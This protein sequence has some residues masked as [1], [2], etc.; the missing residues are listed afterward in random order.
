[1]RVLHYLGLVAVLCG[2][3]G[4][5][6]KDTVLLSQ[7][8]IE[9]QQHV[10]QQ[11]SLLDRDLLRLRDQVESFLL[12]TDLVLGAQESYLVDG[13]V[14]Q[15]SQIQR[16]MASL[17]Q[18]VNALPNPIKLALGDVQTAG[19]ALARDLA[20]YAL[21]ETS[22]TAAEQERWLARIDS[23][24][25]VMITAMQS[26][27][28][29][30][31]DILASASANSRDASASGRRNIQLLVVLYGA[32]VLAVLASASRAVSRPIQ[33]LRGAVEEATDRGAPFDPPAQ[34]PSEVRSLTYHI[35]RLIGSL[36]NELRITRAITEAIP[37]TLLVLDRAKGIRYVKPAADLLPE[38][39][40]MDVS[41]WNFLQHLSSEDA[42]KALNMITACVNTRKADGSTFK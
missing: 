13:A 9:D 12:T 33:T 8:T 6:L 18:D 19:R 7:E 35:S 26:I 39:L 30:M 34:G 10:L 28:A 38:L 23:L 16:T 32:F 3:G 37:D 29:D 24:A 22:P 42:D 4:V 41:G 25:A 36:R 2:T 20:D 27:A 5:F 31:T 17:Q 14:Q 21:L 11:A 15:F 1:M 40:A